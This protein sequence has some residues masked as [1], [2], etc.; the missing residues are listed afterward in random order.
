M[1]SEWVFGIFVPLIGSILANAM[2]CVPVQNTLNARKPD[3]NIELEPIPFVVTVLNCMG[4]TLY[5]FLIMD[6]FV[7]SANAFGILVGLFNTTSYIM[8]TADKNRD[9]M[10]SSTEIGLLLAASFWILLMLV[11]FFSSQSTD[12]ITTVVGICTCTITALYYCSP[13]ANLLLTRNFATID[14]IYLPMGITNLI[15]AL[16]WTLYGAF[17][18]GDIFVWLPNLIGTIASVILVSL[19][20]IRTFVSKKQALAS[21]ATMH[22]IA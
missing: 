12:T 4:W 3:S 16:T 6:P 18:I 21:S 15:C 5:S 7:F 13:M 20:L 8:L 14:V 19:K 2:W 1:A 10:I 9:S 11:L 17:G 22:S